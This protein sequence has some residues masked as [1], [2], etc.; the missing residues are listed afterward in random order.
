M[1]WIAPIGVVSGGFDD[2][3]AVDVRLF[4]ADTLQ[5]VG[6]PATKGIA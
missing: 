4:T 1:R 5:R 6:T 2:K 3:T